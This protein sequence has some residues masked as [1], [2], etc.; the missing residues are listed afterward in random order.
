MKSVI[1]SIASLQPPVFE[2]IDNELTVAISSLSIGGAERIVLDW[3]RRI[4]PCWR[5]HLIVL[6]NRNQEWFVPSFIRVTRLEDADLLARFPSD[7]DISLKRLAQLRG[8]GG[9]IGKKPNPVIV[10][11]LLNQKER[12]ALAEGGASIVTVLHNAK[13]GWPEGPNHLVGSFQTIAVSSACADDLR[14]S[15]WNGSVSVIRHIPAR[16]LPQWDHRA[17]I[18]ERWGVP[19]D[20]LVIGM[21]GAVKKQ[22][23]YPF[24]LHI[25]RDFL[26]K[27]SA[28]LV[29]LGGSIGQSAREDWQTIVQMVYDLGLRNNVAMPGFT[30]DA[31]AYL[32]AFDMLLNTSHFEGLSIATLEALMMGMPVVASAVGGQGEISCDGLKLIPLDSD[33]DT[34]VD[35]LDQSVGKRFN[36]PDW[37]TFPSFRLWTLAGIARPTED[38]SRVMFVTAN[39][40]SGGA[41]RSLV[42]LAKSLQGELD[43]CIVV[44]GNSTDTYFYSDLLGAGVEV[45]RSSDNQNSFNNAESLAMMICSENIGTVCFWNLDPK[46]KLL[47]VKAFGFSSVRFIDVSPGDEAFDSLESIGEFQRFIAFTKEEFYARLDTLVLKYNGRIP[48]GCEEKTLVIPNGV[49]EQSIVKTNY[50]LQGVPRIVVNGRIAETKFLLEIIQAVRIIQESFPLAELHV[51]GSAEPGKQ[52]YAERVFESAGEDT[53]RTIFFHG[54]NFET[55]RLLSEYDVCVVLGKDQGC[56]NALLEALS[57]GVPVVAN[58]DGGTR[59]QVIHEIT[60]LLIANRS[61]VELAAALVRVLHDRNFAQSIGCGGRVHVLEQFSMGRMKQAYM[62]LLGHCRDLRTRSGFS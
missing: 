48:S 4:Y 54:A 44:A 41:Q 42:N 10:C 15:N 23:N 34:W 35:A 29:I 36:E 26:R 25:F 31:S 61:P 59:E 1:V 12:Q 16:R 21:V 55:V 28:Y 2:I 17:E 22:K 8:I 62:D 56:P 19:P 49:P 40:N 5:V 53:D 20:A 51:Y 50:L 39:L 45:Y 7:M 60:G 52:S 9:D 57:V 27:Q 3:A 47:L 13:D 37:A 33:N 46:I 18:R 58:D 14:A 32:C 38:S 43:F 11:H 6:R 30:P 24:A